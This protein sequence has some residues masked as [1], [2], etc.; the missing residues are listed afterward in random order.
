[1]SII[2]S[3]LFFML[4]ALLYAYILGVWAV[5]LMLVVLGIKHS[6]PI[7]D[8]WGFAVLSLSSWVFI[9]DVLEDWLKED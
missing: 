2:L 1:M 4:T 7:K 3:V 8:W 9:Y 6:V 5:F